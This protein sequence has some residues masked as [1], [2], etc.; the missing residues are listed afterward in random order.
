MS[1]NVR[2][3]SGLTSDLLALRNANE[4]RAELPAERAWK[5]ALDANRQKDR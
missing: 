4:I 1:C 5:H 3:V 2:I